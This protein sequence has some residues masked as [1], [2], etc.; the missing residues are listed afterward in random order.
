MYLFDLHIQRLIID[1]YWYTIIYIFLNYIGYYIYTIYNVGK[2]I[3]S[4]A[5][6]WEWQPYHLYIY[7]DDWGMVQ[8]ALCYLY[9]TI[10]GIDYYNP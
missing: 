7:S 3:I 1:I 5:H 8:M 6:D 4:S 2:L 9:Y 10:M